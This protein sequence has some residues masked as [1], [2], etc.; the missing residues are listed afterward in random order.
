[1]ITLFDHDIVFLGNVRFL[2][3]KNT[4][5][6]INATSGIWGIIDSFMLSKVKYCIDNK[7]SP[8][9]YIAGIE[10]NADKQQLT[11]IFQTLIELEMIGNSNEENLEIEPKEVEFK[12]TNRCNLKCLHCGASCD[13]TNKDILTTDE[14][15][16]IFDK[17]S[18]TNVDT[19]LLTGGEP[20]MR[21]D[22]KLLLPYI[23]H[24]F[25]GNISMITNGVLINKE[26]AFLLKEYIDTVSISIDGYDEKSTEFI[27]GTGV[28]N[29]IVQAVDN[30]ETAGF[31]K[32]TII[33]TM[34]LTKQNFDHQTDFY[35][36]CDKLNVT[37]IIR[38]LTALGR[39]YDNYENICAKESFSFTLKSDEEL[40]DIRE[41]LK[42]QI[43]CKAG[44]KKLTINQLGDIYPC[45]MLETE[46]YKLGNILTQDFNDIFTSD[47]Y[48]Q[49]I[50]DKI[51]K[52]VVDTINEC[53]DCNVRYFCMNAC[54]GI[55]NSI[56]NNKEICKEHCKQV[57]PYLNK[58]LWDE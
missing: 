35:K 10:N 15:K 23:R 34:V 28:Y 46:E 16:T 31:N 9:N 52:S 7:I 50:K 20:L 26:M 29:K 38:Q 17:I 44:I 19:L 21:S 2:K 37:G 13:I 14:L 25:K 22:I 1:M 43:I 12:L 57:R 42:C 36:L 48:R 30:L 41:S 39:A 6:I 40:E 55:S 5:I 32:D 4:E 11:E 3:N 49:F 51:M 24:T 27:R 45:L 47:K 18:Q 54:L 58:I 53:K 56:Y 33:L 8:A